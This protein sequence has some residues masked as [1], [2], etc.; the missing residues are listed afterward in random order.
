MAPSKIWHFFTRDTNNT[1]A[2]CKLCER[3][4]KHSKSTTC[5]WN[6]YKSQHGSKDGVGAV[7]LKQKRSCTNENSSDIDQ[8]GKLTPNNSIHNSTS[9]HSCCASTSSLC[10]SSSSL[11]PDL[12]ANKRIRLCDV[13]LA[14]VS[15]RPLSNSRK[16][17][18]T[19]AICNMLC[20]DLIPTSIIE[21]N[22]FRNL[23]Q[24]IEPSY[25]IP[26]RNVLTARI[27]KKLKTSF[28]YE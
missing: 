12:S 23:I 21:C 19:E 3:V 7:R 14:P 20:E 8:D 24:V 5:L 6:H 28:F 10:S 15:M 18:I 11:K 13:A 4:I 26:S 2:V 22:G 17:L 9:P 27:Q 25:V 16:E 1:I